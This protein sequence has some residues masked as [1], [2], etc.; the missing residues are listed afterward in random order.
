MQT[1]D[2]VP[3][4][5]LAEWYTPHLNGRAITDVAQC[6]Q[7]SLATLPTRSHRPELLY[8]LQVPQD[9]YAFGVFAADSAE[10]VAQIC[11]LAGLPADRITAAVEADQLDSPLD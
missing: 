10:I 1:G 9:A 3:S 11:R 5:F 7:Q 2:A 8:A 6:L 4:R